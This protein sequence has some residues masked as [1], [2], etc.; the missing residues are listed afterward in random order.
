ME[1][2]RPEVDVKPVEI[3]HLDFLR[4]SDPPK[5][6]VVGETLSDLLLPSMPALIIAVDTDMKVT[7]GENYVTGELCSGSCSKAETVDINLNPGLYLVVRKAKCS[8]GHDP[9]RSEYTAG[10][11]EICNEIITIRNMLSQLN[12]AYDEFRANMVGTSKSNKFAETKIDSGAFLG[13]LG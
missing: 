9:G 11:G 10:F 8:L 3:G 2:E 7:S 4:L 6:L 1:I 12:I 5:R 13:R